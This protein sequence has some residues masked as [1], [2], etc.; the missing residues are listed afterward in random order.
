LCIHLFSSAE[1]VL[2][3]A[4]FDGEKK[5]KLNNRVF[6]CGLEKKKKTTMKSRGGKS[7][8]SRF[9]T[10]MPWA[11]FVIC[12]M[13]IGPARPSDLLHTV[14][15]KPDV[16]VVHWTP[17]D[18]HITFEIVAAT[19]GFVG[20]GFSAHG[21]MQ[22]ADFMIGWVQDGIPFVQ[23]R[24]APR[25]LIGL[26]GIND[27]RREHG[28]GHSARV[29]LLGIHVIIS[30]LGPVHFSWFCTSYDKLVFFSSQ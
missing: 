9:T 1:Q 18:T 29:V 7:V 20:L 27:S 3:G 21:R 19:H 24:T 25:R 17:D 22:G 28:R 30:A 23:V 5:K 14:V 15:L 11:T 2:F 8:F 4:G 16:F 6:Q 13:C 12:L 26:P 10:T